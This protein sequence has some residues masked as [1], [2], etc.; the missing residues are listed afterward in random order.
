MPFDEDRV[1]TRAEIFEHAEGDIYKLDAWLNSLSLPVG[2]KEAI[3]SD[4]E[5]YAY[6]EQEK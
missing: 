1:P 4:L 6:E 3:Y 5:S 2:A